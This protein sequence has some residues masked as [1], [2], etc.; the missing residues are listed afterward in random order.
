MSDVQTAAAAPPTKVPG[1]AWVLAVLT[2]VYTFNHLDRQVII[3]VLEPI[4]QAMGL[5]DEQAGLLTG[6]SFALVYATLGIPVAFLA[7]RSNRRNII[8]LAL[9][10]WSGAT[11]VCGFAQN[12]WQLFL[13][14][15]G[16][17]VGE[18]GGTPPATSMIAD[19]Y[20]PRERAM[21]LGIYTTGIGFGIMLGYVLSAFVY[22]HYGW[23]AAFFAAGVPGIILAI[24]L[25]FTVKEPERGGAEDNIQAKPA[26]D[27]P[28]LGET[29]KFMFSQRSYLLLLLGCLFI[30]ISAN[31]YV[32]FTASHLIRTFE[33]DITAEGRLFWEISIPLGLLIGGVGSIGAVVLGMVCDKLSAKD[34]RWRPWIIAATSAVALPFAFMFLQATSLRE[35]YL[36][37]IVPNFVGLIYASIAYTASQELVK[38]RMRSFSSAFTLF[39]LTLIGIS[40][41]PWITGKLSDMFQTGGLDQAMALKDALQYVLIFNAIAVVCLIFAGLNYRKDVARAQGG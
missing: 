10:F 21:A 18:A 33:I 28:S 41:G 24:I 15:V 2:M 8:A 13:A 20:G 4:K 19:L 3:T 14:R 38:V 11:A 25:R 16:V 1:R 37:N 39:C 27:A 31:A 9:L 32:S 5:S 23:R 36:W 12:F 29:I 26:E 7:D 30:C 17:G 6:L 34:L 40:G 35:A 22:E